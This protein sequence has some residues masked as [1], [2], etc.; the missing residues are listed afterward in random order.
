LSPWE[1]NGNYTGQNAVY[2][3]YSDLAMYKKRL[4]SRIYS[5]LLL[6]IISYNT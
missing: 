5:S 2:V 6:K 4:V 1:K 3:L